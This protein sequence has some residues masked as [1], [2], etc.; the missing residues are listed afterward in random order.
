[1]RHDEARLSDQFRDLISRAKREMFTVFRQCFS[2]AG[3]YDHVLPGSGGDRV[4]FVHQPSELE[5]HC[6]E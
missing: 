6:S 2:H 4:H 3:L 1:M 5:V